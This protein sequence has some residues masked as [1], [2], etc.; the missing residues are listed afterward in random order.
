VEGLKQSV[1]SKTSTLIRRSQ[2]EIKMDILRAVKE[3]IEKPTQIMYKA[4]ISWTI[5]QTHLKSLVENGFL[6]E[7]ECG[8]RKRYEL[9][10]KG[11]NILRAYCNILEQMGENRTSF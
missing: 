2:L 1:V 7:I 9:T 6:T 5:L 3:G 10:Q 4:N 8:S 11:F